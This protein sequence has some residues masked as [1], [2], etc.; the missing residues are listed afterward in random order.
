MLLKFV[1]N[2]QKDTYF[3]F[4]LFSYYI[5]F[6]L[7]KLEDVATGIWIQ[8][9]K[10]SG[11]EVNYVN[12]D[13]FHNAGCESDYVLAH[14]Q[15][16]RLMLCLWGKLRHEHEAVCCEQ[17]LHLPHFSLLGQGLWLGGAWHHS[18]QSGVSK[19]FPQGILC[20]VCCM[21]YGNLFF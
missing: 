13:R 9:F 2:N 17:L 11:Q 16:P 1:D 4:L 14:Y 15:G 6:Q 7:F 18:C 12:D 20:E 19:R 21:N 5:A 10:R 3:S 8:E